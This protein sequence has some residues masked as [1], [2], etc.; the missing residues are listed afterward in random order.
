MEDDKKQITIVCPECENE[1]EHNAS[2][3][4]IGDIIECPVCGANLE[5][6]SIDPV[7]VEP[8]TTYK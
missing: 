2:E 8:V 1:F 3:L 4:E 6:V 5:V 7:K